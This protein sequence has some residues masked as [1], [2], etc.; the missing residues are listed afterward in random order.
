V[1]YRYT[2][3]RGRYWDRTSDPLTPFIELPH[4]KIN[5]DFQAFEM[6]VDYYSPNLSQACLAV[7][8]AT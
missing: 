3:K 4:P 6:V 7:E 8:G 1:R 5:E 2:G